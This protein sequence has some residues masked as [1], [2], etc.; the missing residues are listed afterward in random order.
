ALLAATG[1]QTE[2][3]PPS[4][5]LIIIGS[6]TGVSISALFTA[7][8]LPAALA[9]LA[10]VAIVL[11]RSRHDRTDLA[12]RPSLGWIAKAFFIAIPGL[13]LPVLIRA[14]VL[15]GV[16]TATEVST[17][18]ILYTM[19]VG[20]AIY[21]EFDWRRMYPILRETSALTGALLLIIA[22]ATSMGWALTQSGFAQDLADALG[23][24]PG[25]VGGFLALSVV[26]F[27]VLGSVLEGVPAIVLFGPLLFPVA[28]A[29][30]VNEVHYAV[31]VVLSM[32]IGLFSPPL[33]VGYY[34]ACA[35][36]K[37]EPDA[38]MRRVVPYLAA[39]LVATIVVAAVPWLSLGFLHGGR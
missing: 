19:I 17:V 26:A 29:F 35:I 37:T 28:K 21:R 5:V 10:L 24:S 25:G 39:V 2:T 14:A 27:I 6:V 38:A 16:A 33:G 13:A 8:L 15:G 18:G 12:R 31:V 4:L 23:K 32:G 7:G 9:A 36:G 20:I 30:G 11:L 1:A 34:A 3:I 22:T